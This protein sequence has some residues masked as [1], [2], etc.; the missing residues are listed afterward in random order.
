MFEATLLVGLDECDV[1]RTR[2]FPECSTCVLF[3]ELVVAEEFLADH[4]VAGIVVDKI[5]AVVE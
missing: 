1:A 5:A 3:R 2:Q 4:S